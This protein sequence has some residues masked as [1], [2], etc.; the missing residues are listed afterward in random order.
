MKSTRKKIPLFKTE[1]HEREFWSKN[2]P[3][4]FMDID[5]ARQGAFPNLKPTLKSIS[6]RLPEHMLEQLK[7][8]AHKKD[9]PYQSL[10]K[11]FLGREILMERR[12]LESSK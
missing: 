8:L 11:L 2:S 6:I 10:V 1:D 5:S 12:S 9:I 3:L 7:I 4:D